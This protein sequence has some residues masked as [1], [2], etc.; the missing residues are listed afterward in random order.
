MPLSLSEVDSLVEQ[1][2]DD[3]TITADRA[4]QAQSAALSF[5]YPKAVLGFRDTA[6]NSYHLARDAIQIGKAITY[7]KLSKD[8]E[9]WLKNK[10]QDAEK[11]AKTYSFQRN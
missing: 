7:R 11:R 2:L 5:N 6:R 9:T 1:F 10:L 3:A 4:I 8:D